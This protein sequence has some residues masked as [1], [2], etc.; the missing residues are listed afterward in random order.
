[1]ALKGVLGAGGGRG[2]EGGRGPDGP[3][4]PGPRGSGSGR[5]WFGRGGAGL[6]DRQGDALAVLL[7]LQHAHLDPIAHLHHLGRV[8]DELVGQLADVDQAVL[9]HADV[10][11]GAEG[12]HVGD[13]ALE[14]HALLQVLDLGDV[15]AEAATPRSS[16]AGRGPG[17]S[18][19]AD[20]VA[21]GGHAPALVDVFADVDACRTSSLLPT[22]AGH[23][24]AQI[25]RPCARPRRSSR[26]APRW[27][28][29]GS[30]APR[31]RR[32]PAA[33]SNAL[34]PRRGTF[35]RS[36]RERKGPLASRCSTMFLAR[37]APSPRR[38]PAA[39][40]RRCSPPRP[41][42]SRR[43]R[44]R[45]RARLPSGAWLTSCWY[46]PTPMDLGSIFTSSASGSCSRRPIETAPRTV[47]S[48][49]G[50]SSRAISEAE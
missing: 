38:R 44:P 16:G 50:N 6:L 14:H 30:R 21:Q 17:F 49:S 22:S 29:A 10:D 15:L 48:W 19:S 42:R 3:R 35:L 34:G 12:G 24:H 39:W 11:E 45:R 27:R 33:C 25:A 9:V 13:D 2:P 47:T 18:S 41:P 7:H 31:T 46:W 37:V 40:P 43:T 36:R 28:R 8:L 23:R 4:G 26:G 32:K 5:G 20:D 1:M